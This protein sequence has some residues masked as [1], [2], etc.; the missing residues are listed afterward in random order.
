VLSSVLIINLII[1]MMG[2]TFADDG[3]G[4]AH[5]C[6]RLENTWVLL[7]KDL[8][9]HYGPSTTDQALRTKHWSEFGVIY[10]KF[11]DS[12]SESPKAHWLWQRTALV[13]SPTS[14]N[15]IETLFQ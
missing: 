3:E 14:L 15:E 7:V 13:P 10:S 6:E 4:L 12:P 8:K 1:A 2:K 9:I 11:Q 5:T